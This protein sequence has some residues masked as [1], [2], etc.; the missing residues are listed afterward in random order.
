MSSPSAL[1]KSV[2]DWEIFLLSR[3]HTREISC[4]GGNSYLGLLAETFHLPGVVSD[5]DR[6]IVYPKMVQA[7]LNCWSELA[8]VNRDPYEDEPITLIAQMAFNKNGYLDENLRCY[9]VR[10]WEESPRP[11]SCHHLTIAL[12]SKGALPVTRAAVAQLFKMEGW[13]LVVARL[14]CQKGWMNDAVEFCEEL[15]KNNVGVSSFEIDSVVRAGF[16]KLKGL[17]WMRLLHNNSKSGQLFIKRYE[18]ELL[19]TGISKAEIDY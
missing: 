12:N 11:H 13:G 8:S 17:R 10:L 5:S 15:Q 4:P 14:A 16:P 7:V 18:E 3:N 2:S 1:E 9:Y 19:V 6:Q